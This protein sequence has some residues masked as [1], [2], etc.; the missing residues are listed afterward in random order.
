VVLLASQALKGIAIETVSPGLFLTQDYLDVGQLD[1]A[2]RLGEDCA[3][4]IRGPL[5]LVLQIRSRQ[6]APPGCRDYFVG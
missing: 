1:S 5:G 4:V 3:A 2:I 6:L